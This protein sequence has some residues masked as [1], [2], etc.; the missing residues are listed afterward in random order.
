MPRKYFALA[1]NAS[2]YIIFNSLCNNY[3]VIRSYVNLGYCSSFVTN[4]TSIRCSV[5]K[6]RYHIIRTMLHVSVNN[7]EVS[8]ISLRFQLNTCVFITT[9]LSHLELTQQGYLKCVYSSNTTI[10]KLPR[11]QNTLR[12]LF[13]CKG[14]RAQNTVT[15]IWYLLNVNASY[16][17]FITR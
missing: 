15:L 10:A 6:F 5:V 11:T 16:L 12:S 2:F 4:I 1:T 3:R 7:S 14:F 9:A 13:N 17:T 8:I